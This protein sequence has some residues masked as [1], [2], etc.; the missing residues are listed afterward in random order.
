VNLSAGDTEGVRGLCLAPHDLAIAGYAAS[1][2]KDLIFTRELAHRGMVSEE[3]LLS[4]LGQTPADEQMRDRIRNQTARDFHADQ[5]L[6]LRPRK[7]NWH[8]TIGCRLG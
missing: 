4:L 6:G 8:S 7:S 3:R 5:D 2:K 1:R